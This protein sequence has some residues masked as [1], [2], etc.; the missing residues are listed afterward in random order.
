MAPTTVLQ[1]IRDA[2]R[3]MIG[4]LIDHVAFHT[5]AKR[6]EL[7]DVLKECLAFTRKS[8]DSVYTGIGASEIVQ[9]LQ[10]AI[11]RLERGKRIN[12]LKLSFLFLPTG[13]LQ[14]TAIDNGW[15]DEFLDLSDRFD[16]AIK[17]HP[18]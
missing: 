8:E 15:G 7:V 9:T 17:G 12:K 1:H 13:D 5:P 16:S 2:L 18:S 3:R 14:E 4:F 6:Q 10:R 11:A